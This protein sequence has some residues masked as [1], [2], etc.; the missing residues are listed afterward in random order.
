VDCH[1]I[2]FSLLGTKVLDT[3][4]K[5]PGAF[6]AETPVFRERGVKYEK[7]DNP[8]LEKYPA[9]LNQTKKYIFYFSYS[10]I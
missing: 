10:F 5:N 1:L 9:K 7:K 4:S 3:N 6:S 8:Y 2:V